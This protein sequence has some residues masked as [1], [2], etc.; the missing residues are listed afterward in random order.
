MSG[1]DKYACFQ[2]IRDVRSQM[3]EDM[4]GMSP[5]ERVA[6][7]REGAEKALSLM[8]KLSREEARLRRQAI[9]CPEL[10]VP[11]RKSEAR[12]R[13]VSRGRSVKKLVHA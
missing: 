7:I 11:P 2:W 10:G 3:S 6:Y 4:E 13:S 5:E 9:L 12:K 1:K 8:P